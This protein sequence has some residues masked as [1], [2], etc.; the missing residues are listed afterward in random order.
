MK[1]SNNTSK[2][3]GTTE[4]FIWSRPP[5]GFLKCNVDASIF[6]ASGKV[7]YGCIIHDYSG[8]FVAAKSSSN[9]CS[10]LTPA[11]AEAFGIREV[12]S[13]IKTSDFVTVLVETDALVV[14][15]VILHRTSDVSCFDLVYRGLYCFT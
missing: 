12:L 10:V 13:W 2:A 3:L 9:L 6:P 5:V 1:V 4:G 15:I 7:G 8:A 14:V 11:V